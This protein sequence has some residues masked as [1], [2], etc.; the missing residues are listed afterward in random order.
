MSRM[1]LRPMRF[2]DGLLE[3]APAQGSF[4]GVVGETDAT[5]LEE[6]GEHRLAV[7]QVI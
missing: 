4:G 5:V 7:E 2:L 6:A 3:E 1:G